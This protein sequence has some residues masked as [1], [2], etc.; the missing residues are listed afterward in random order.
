[1]LACAAGLAYKLERGEDLPDSR[2][3]RASAWELRRE[4]GCTFK[5]RCVV[6]ATDCSNTFIAARLKDGATTHA[7]HT[8]RKHIS[9]ESR[10]CWCGYSPIMLQTRLAYRSGTVFSWSP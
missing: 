3:V 7:Q 1:M 8:C 2:N 10:S 4:L 9:H 6:R 5:V